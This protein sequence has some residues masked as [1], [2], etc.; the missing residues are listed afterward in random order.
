MERKEPRGFSITSK[1]K[2]VEFYNQNKKYFELAEQ[3]HSDKDLFPIHKNILSKCKKK[4]GLIVDLGCGTGLD[5]FAM[6]GKNNFCLGLDISSLAIKKAQDKIKDRKNI[7]FQKAN[8]ENLPLKNNSV[9][10]VTSF[11]TFEHLFGPEKV[12]SEINRVLKPEGEL[13]ILCPNFVSPFR[14]APVFG[15]VRK[16]KIIKKMILSFIRIFNV[17]FLRKKDFKVNFIDG[18]LIDLNKVGYDWDAANE[19]S[20]FEFANYFYN[21]KYKID[22]GTWLSPPKTKIENIFSYFKNFPIIKY[23]GPLCYLYAQKK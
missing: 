21:K 16:I 5:T 22:Y 20:M 6:A 12:L 4:K 9:D 23:W 1:E 11:F 7:N 19:P 15:G 2:L 8:L 18:S 17:R 14:G 13:F 10:V 3:G